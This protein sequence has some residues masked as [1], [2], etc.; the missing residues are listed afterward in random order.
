[1]IDVRKLLK[2]LNETEKRER[3]RDRERE[4]D[5]REERKKKMIRSSRSN[6]DA[7]DRIINRMDGRTMASYA[8]GK[9][10]FGM[11]RDGGDG[12]EGFGCP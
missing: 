8:R 10:G 5:I 4:R 2:K 11:A 9:S 1:M 6:S 7:N 12:G 3:Q